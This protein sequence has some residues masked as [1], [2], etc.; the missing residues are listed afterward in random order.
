MLVYKIKFVQ[1]LKQ[2]DCQSYRTF[3]EWAQKKM[4]NDSEVY[5]KTL[6]R[7]ETYF[8]FKWYVN[9]QNR[10]FWSDDNPQAIVEM[11]LHRQKVNV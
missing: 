9:E 6:L 5:K 2:N 7:D 1:E 11:P 4:V 10:R 8:W 3:G